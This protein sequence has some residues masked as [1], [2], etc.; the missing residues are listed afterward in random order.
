MNLKY[1]IPV[2]RRPPR[3]EARRPRS[4]QAARRGNG[5]RGSGGLRGLALRLQ[6]QQ[7]LADLLVARVQVRP[8]LPQLGE[9]LPL[10]EQ[11]LGA[12]RGIGQPQP[13]D[14]L[15]EAFGHATSP[16]ARADPHSGAK[17][18]EEGA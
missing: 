6:R 17:F 16:V 7:R 14:G 10:S 1:F 12:E 18:G 3:G 11:R 13:A 4:Q 9:Q 8:L 5:R 15:Q 2:D